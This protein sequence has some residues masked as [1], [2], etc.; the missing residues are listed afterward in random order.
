MSN[1]PYLFGAFVL[2]GALL[3]L[4]TV[5][6]RRGLWLRAGA[7]GLFALLAAMQFASL[8]DLLSRP[9]PAGLEFWS[10]ATE[11]ALV[12]A[13]KIDEGRAI[14]VWLKLPGI[15]EP[16]YYEL[17]WSREAA[18]DL[19]KAMR[20]AGQHGSQIVLRLP[21]DRAGEEKT[22]PKFYDVPRAKLPDKP[23]Q[24]AHEYRHP[25]ISI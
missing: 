3:A 19:Q 11:E 18:I 21:F 15:R 25:S 12:M 8:V 1:L 20:A 24:D 2:V 23:P 9:K 10:S 6:A 7:V 22:V 14:Y 5:W 13:A 16:R 17:P 4:I